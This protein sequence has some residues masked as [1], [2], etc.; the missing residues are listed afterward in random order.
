MRAFHAVHDPAH[1]IRRLDRERLGITARGH[2]REHHHVG[3]AIEKYVFHEFFGAE[4]VE[5][6]ARPGFGSETAAHFGRPFESIGRSCLHPRA[7]GVDEVT[8]HVEDKFTLAADPRLREL[9]LERGF[10]F[11]L[12]EAAAL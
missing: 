3:V 8:L 1:R 5:I 7:G 10:T 9:R 6:T 4:T 12:E 2:E 11:E